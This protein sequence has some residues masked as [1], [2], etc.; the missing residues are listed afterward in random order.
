MRE[1]RVLPMLPLLDTLVIRQRYPDHLLIILKHPRLNPDLLSLNI[2]LRRRTNLTRNL[3]AL[4]KLR[5]V[6]RN[7]DLR[8]QRNEVF[9]E[10]H[11]QPILELCLVMKEMTGNK[12]S[13]PKRP[14]T[15][16]LSISIPE[17]R[18]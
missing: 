1:Q 18:D 17:F 5:L 11:T 4:S 16:K 7:P 13:Q 3:L 15:G 14:G 2:V 10:T 6:Q 8:F 9:E 12:K